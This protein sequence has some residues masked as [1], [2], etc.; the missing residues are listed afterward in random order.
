MVVPYL[1]LKY[2][3]VCQKVFKSYFNLILLALVVVSMGVMNSQIMLDR[4]G[5]Y[6]AGTIAYATLVPWGVMLGATIAVLEFMPGWKQ[7][8]AN[9]FGYL[10]FKF[11]GGGPAVLN[12]LKPNLDSLKYITEDP[13]LLANKFTDS[14]FDEMF[15][16][17]IQQDVFKPDGVPDDFRKVVVLKDT[18]SE[19]VW[20]I[21]VGAVAMTTSHSIILNYKCTLVNQSPV[22]PPPGPPVSSTTYVNT[23]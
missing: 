18:V 21:L 9:T 8:F 16:S 6:S 19:F 12:L 3:L 1:V 13:S 15:A 2:N 5:T 14:N 22:P 7:P 17:F 10:F 20:Y 4:C 11:A 23:S